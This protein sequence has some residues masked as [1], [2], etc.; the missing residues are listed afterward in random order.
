MFALVVCSVGEESI[1]GT[2]SIFQGLLAF[3]FD[4]STLFIPFV[5]FILSDHSNSNP[6]C[7]IYDVCVIRWNITISLKYKCH[8]KWIPAEQGW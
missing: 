6:P 4:T 8:N 3:L 2:C 1:T 7:D 5:P